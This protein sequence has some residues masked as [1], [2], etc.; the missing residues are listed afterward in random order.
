METQI[1]KSLI[2][3]FN[4]EPTKENWTL[5]ETHLQDKHFCKD[6]GES[7]FYDN[8]KIR[9]SKEGVLYYDPG[10]TSCK[11]HKKIGENIYYLHVCQ[12]CVGKK[13][14]EYLKMNRS[15][16]FNVMNVITRYAFNI[17]PEEAKKFTKSTAVTLENLVNK[18]GEKEGLERWE[19]YRKLQA[20]TNTFEYKRDNYGWNQKD[21][22]DFNKSR[23]V[24][25][26]NM[27][28]KHG[29]ERGREIFNQYVEKQKVNGKTLDYFIEK[30]GE[31]NGRIRYK[32]IS[33]GKA[34]GGYI[35]G[36]S[37]SKAS[38]EFFYV[39]DKE[40]SKLYKTY[41]ASKNN[42]KVV[43]I[44]EI[45]KC[46]LLDYYIE[47]INVCIEFNGDYYHANPK[48][49]HK[50]FEFPE[51]SKDIV[52]KAEDLWEKDKKKKYHL[53]KSLNI[54]T[55]VVWESDYYKNKDNDDFYKKIIKQ[56]IEK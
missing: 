3:R 25:L 20:E 10:M 53:Q 32:E 54:Q 5:L 34:K 40:I 15:R 21:F 17:P 9:I 43:Y 7:I 49:Y 46:Y 26:K 47:G 24:T 38:Q 2:R 55:I 11:T 33:L 28:K 16:V 12:I 13:F 44:D 37:Y 52:L 41:F 35:S 22:E 8:S 19:K 4:K 23:A 50:D 30:F 45:D 39:I 48:K 1:L 31:L 56:C 29:E 14:P 36:S 27:V 51:F 18:Y 6:C 42:E